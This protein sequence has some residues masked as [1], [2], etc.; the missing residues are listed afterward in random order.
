MFDVITLDYPQFINIVTKKKARIQYIEK[1]NQYCIF[2]YDG[3]IKYYTCIYKQNPNIGNFDWDREQQYLNDFET[4]YK[5]NANRPI[6]ISSV[7]GDSKFYSYLLEIP[8]NQ[9]SGIIEIDFGNIYNKDIE[10][11]KVRPRPVQ[12]K[13]G[14]K[15]RLEAWTKAGIIGSDPVKVREFGEILLEGGDGWIG[16]WY[17]GVGTGLIPSYVLLKLIYEK[18]QDLSYRRFYIDV[19]IIV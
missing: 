13:M 18:G 5:N 11:R 17:E 1:N 19:E 3:P 9:S 7:E 6:G 10:L 12:A 4:N 16:E 8:D 15:V 2:A 14:D